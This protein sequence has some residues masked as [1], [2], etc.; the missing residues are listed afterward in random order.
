MTK[1]RKE[2]KEREKK[3][4]PTLIGKAVAL[5]LRISSVGDWGLGGPSSGQPQACSRALTA[6]HI[7]VRIP[8]RNQH[9]E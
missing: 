7:A 8:T 9:D 2:K 6:D 3:A 5:R 4:R 1:K